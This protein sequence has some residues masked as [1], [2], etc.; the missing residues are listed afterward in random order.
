MTLKEAANFIDGMELPD[1]RS[2]SFKMSRCEGAVPP[3]SLLSSQLHEDRLPSRV[4]VNIEPLEP[5][6][7]S[8]YTDNKLDTCTISP[9]SNYGP[10][11]ESL[12]ETPRSELITRGLH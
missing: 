6:S 9:P 1:S 11:L 8:V 3:N 7:E 5:H 10:S 12:Q 2:D 4:V